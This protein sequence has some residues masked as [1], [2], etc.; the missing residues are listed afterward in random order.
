MA[1]R[2]LSITTSLILWATLST[3]NAQET[4][5]A[6]A[7]YCRFVPEVTTGAPTS[8]RA[9]SSFGLCLGFIMGVTDGYVIGSIKSGSTALPWCLNG[10]QAT[11]EQQAAIWVKWMDKTP[12]RWHEP[13]SITFVAAMREAF[14]CRN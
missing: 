2:C 10:Q 12:Q 8:A 4:A 11:R 14:P 5:K 6:I 9:A 3:V 13:A 1:M 7:D